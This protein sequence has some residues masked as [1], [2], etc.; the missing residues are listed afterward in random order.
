M[1][2]GK[3]V[4][5]WSGFQAQLVITEVEL[6]REILND[7]DGNFVKVD[8]EGFIKKLLGGG[9]GMIDGEKWAKRRKLAN[10]AF[11]G[12]SLKVSSFLFVKFIRVSPQ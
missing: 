12:A 1:I 2:T 6:I 10:H 3:N 9:L 5:Q 7:K 11:H 4:L 8:P